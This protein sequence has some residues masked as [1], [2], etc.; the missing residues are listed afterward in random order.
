MAA[1]RLEL[2]GQWGAALPEKLCARFLRYHLRRPAL[3]HARPAILARP[4]PAALKTRR[5]A[6]HRAPAGALV[7]EPQT[8]RE[9]V[10]WK[11]WVWVLGVRGDC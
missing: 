3:R 4:L 5:T 6:D 2:C 11:E 1:R 8:D 10:V 7:P 9:Q